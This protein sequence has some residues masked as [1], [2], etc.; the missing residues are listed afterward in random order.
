MSATIARK[1]S[2]EERTS[3][4]E[5][6]HYYSRRLVRD[7]EAKGI[8]RTAVESVN[9][10]L[11][12]DDPDVLKA[13]CIR[14]FPAV[15]FP[16]SQ[17]LKREEVE[18]DKTPGASVIHAIHHGNSIKRAMFE[19]APFDLMYGFRGTGYNVDLLSPYEMLLHWS[20]ERIAAPTNATGKLNRA[21]WTQEGLEMKKVCAANKTRPNYY[22]GKHYV[23]ILIHASVNLVVF[24]RGPSPT[25]SQADSFK[26]I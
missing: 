14:T 23:G 5:A 9:L 6:F 24:S 17:L 16:A 25:Q 8:V 20:L 26:N 3:G 2:V 1:I 4:T 22:A 21:T 12:A 7:L 15:T 18:T 19:E 13:E 11:H 10:S